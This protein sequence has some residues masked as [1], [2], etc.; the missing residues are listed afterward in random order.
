MDSHNSISEPTLNKP[1]TTKSTSHILKPE[2][3]DIHTAAKINFDDPIINDVLKPTSTA[4]DAN[5]SDEDN[6]STEDKSI[7]PAFIS[8][9]EQ[10]IAKL[11]TIYGPEIPIDIYAL[12]FIYNIIISEENNVHIEMTLATPSCPVAQIFPETVR[13]TV[14]QI[15]QINSAE[16]ELV[17]RD[18][19]KKEVTNVV[20][21]FCFR[22]LITQDTTTWIEVPEYSIL[23]AWYEK[24]NLSAN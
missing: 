19:L 16:I 4:N 1:A 22:A 5:K 24:K 17:L 2:Q 18:P 9:N 12:G 13:Q 14:M 15:E 6:S 10:V 7:H 3:S 20:D 11:K 8:I 23:S 21:L